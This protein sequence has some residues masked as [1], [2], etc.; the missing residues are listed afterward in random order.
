MMNLKQ[1]KLRCNKNRRV[2]SLS[3]VVQCGI[4]PARVRCDSSGRNSF[5]GTPGTGY[6]D[7]HTQVP[8]YPATQDPLLV[9]SDDLNIFVTVSQT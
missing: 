9:L 1:R 4:Q 6:P 2:P 7:R 5:P 3:P 8:G